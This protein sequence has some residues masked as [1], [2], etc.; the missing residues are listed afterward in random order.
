MGQERTINQPSVLIRRGVGDPALELYFVPNLVVEWGRKQL[1][2]DIYPEG[3][4]FRFP[5]GGAEFYVEVLPPSLSDAD[6]ARGLF[7]LSNRSPERSK[8]VRP[9]GSRTRVG[10]AWYYGPGNV[11]LRMAGRVEIYPRR[12]AMRPATNALQDMGLD[13]REAAAVISE[14]QM[15]LTTLQ[16]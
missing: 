15:L 6:A 4:G 16:A 1:R 5:G 11:G 12:S 3:G 14:I 7:P 8:V 2:G 9:E 10:L 13:G